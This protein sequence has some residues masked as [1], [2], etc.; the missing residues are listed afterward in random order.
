MLKLSHEV[1]VPTSDSTPSPTQPEEP[2]LI[3]D[4]FLRREKLAELLHCS[5]R[6]ID[7]LYALRLGPPRVRFGRSILYN[8]DSVREW[9]RSRE[10]R[11]PSAT[12]RPRLPR[13]K[14]T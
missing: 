11:W 9:L 8:I 12:K 5:V 13:N 1:P 4:K 6:K 7:R 10:E 2:M 3:L 14:H